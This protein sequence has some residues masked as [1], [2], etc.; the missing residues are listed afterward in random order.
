M[1]TI[2][3]T[4]IIITTILVEL[5]AGQLRLMCTDTQAAW[6]RVHGTNFDVQSRVAVSMTYLSRARSSH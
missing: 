5:A 6:V 3:I 1:Y 2:I 4:I